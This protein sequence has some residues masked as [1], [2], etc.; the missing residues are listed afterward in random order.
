[1]IKGEDDQSVEVGQDNTAPHIFDQ[2]NLSIFVK[3]NARDSKESSLEKRKEEASL[4][5]Y[6][7][8]EQTLGIPGTWQDPIEE[9][10]DEEVETIKLKDLEK[11]KAI[12]RPNN[13]ITKTS[14][15][16]FNF[17]LWEKNGGFASKRVI[18]RIFL[19]RPCFQ[20]PAETQS[21]KFM[22][23]T[24]IDTSEPGTNEKPKNPSNPRKTSLMTELSNSEG[25]NSLK[26]HGTEHCSTTA[27]VHLGQRRFK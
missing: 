9:E 20:S 27:D 22:G 4:D 8:K 3:G 14:K 21:S 5:K 15:I 10:G 18:K 17:S 1:M 12:E 7:Q 2:A 11:R 16:K 25:R 23:N 13:S 24:T 26:R 19:N 6:G